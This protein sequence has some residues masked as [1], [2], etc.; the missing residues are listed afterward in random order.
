[1][2]A[3]P[4]YVE[5]DKKDEK[6]VLL[7]SEW[8]QGDDIYRKKTNVGHKIGGWTWPAMGQ[9]TPL[10]RASPG[11]LEKY[12]ELMFEVVA[13]TAD[14]TRIKS[15]VSGGYPK[16][17]LESVCCSHRPSQPSMARR[18][19]FATAFQLMGGLP[20]GCSR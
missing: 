16:G 10:E 4:L 12:C 6:D 2:D 20:S 15:W 1:V 13:F 17:D 5:G 19:L 8:G 18:P 14:K 3:P 11:C 9:D 7:E